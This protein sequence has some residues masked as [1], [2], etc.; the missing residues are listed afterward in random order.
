MEQESWGG[1]VR[2]RTDASHTAGRR[3]ARVARGQRAV[4]TQTSPERRKLP[5]PAGRIGVADFCSWQFS[6]DC[7]FSV[8]DRAEVRA[9]AVEEHAHL[10]RQDLDAI[11]DLLVWQPLDTAQPEH[12][13]LHVG[14][15]G[16]TFSHV[17]HEFLG[18]GVLKR[19]FRLAAWFTHAVDGDGASPFS[20]TLSQPVHRSPG[21]QAGQEGSPIDN[22]L[23]LRESPGGQER[24]LI[25]VQGVGVV[26]EQSVN[27]PP[28]GWTVLLH[29]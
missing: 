23:T 2:Q 18:A 27:S 8:D 11:A 14:K 19:G 28:D 16:Q 17:V 25:A 1:Q 12:L 5:L 7:T 24:F 3:V 21:S 9:G 26:V 6:I 10:A 29:D 22:R 15:F 4:R 13:G 20:V